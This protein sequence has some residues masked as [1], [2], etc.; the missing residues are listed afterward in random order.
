MQDQ[1]TV[2]VGMQSVAFVLRSRLV[3][4][5]WR[6]AMSISNDSLTLLCRSSRRHGLV[7]R[8]F[9]ELNIQ[10][11]ARSWHAYHQARREFDISDGGR[12]NDMQGEV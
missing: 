8:N 10:P 4:R 3:E 11:L 5:D 9:A 7:S 1:A 12:T 2:S 6:F